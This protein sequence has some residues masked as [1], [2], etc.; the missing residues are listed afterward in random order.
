[1]FGSKATIHIK[2]RH[3]CCNAVIDSI[4]V[5]TPVIVDDE[6]VE[7]LAL[8]DYVVHMVSGVRFKTVDEAVEWIRMLDQDDDL[9]D[10]L[11]QRTREFARHKLLN[12]SQDIKRFRL[13]LEKMN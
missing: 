6:T 13:F 7:L 12:T 9:L 5:G 3:V 10:V 2:D 8:E 11:S 1:M 4:S